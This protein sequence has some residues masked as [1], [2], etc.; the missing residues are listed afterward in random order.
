MD[1]PLWE[2]EDNSL[3]WGNPWG[4]PN[5]LW[6][7]DL[8]PLW[9]PTKVYHNNPSETK[10]HPEGVDWDGNPKQPMYVLKTYTT[11]QKGK[12]IQEKDVIRPRNKV[13]E[14]RGEYTTNRFDHSNS[15]LC[16]PTYGN[17]PT[18]FNSG[19]VNKFCSKCNN[20]ECGYVVMYWPYL[21]ESDA[22]IVDAQF[23]SN[24]F[25]AEHENAKADRMSSCE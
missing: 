5:P 15:S 16:C 12:D 17:C 11:D 8:P 20:A 22:R 1:Q 21:K 23:L 4:N 3:P 10:H 7:Y 24:Y 18:C 14:E 25:D 13:F 2:I 9:G 19:P 6:E